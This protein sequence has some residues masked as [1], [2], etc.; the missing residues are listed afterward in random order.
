MSHGVYRLGIAVPEVEPRS[1]KVPRP[2][3]QTRASHSNVKGVNEM[4]R[5]VAGV[6]DEFA[7]CLE[8]YDQQLP[9]TRTGQY[10][11]HR[12]TID[13]RR[14]FTS[15][16]DAIEDEVF[17]RGF[18]QT[19]YAWGIGKRAS[20]L[21]SLPEFRDRL[22]DCGEEIANFEHLRLDDPELDISL[23][24]MRLWRLIERLAVVQN[25][26][27]I[28]PGTKTLHH[29]LPDLVPPMDRAW[30]GAFFQW[31]MGAPAYERST[32]IRTF[33]SFAEIAQATDPSEFVGEEWRT[34]LTKVLDNAIIGY[35]KLHD[36]APR[37]S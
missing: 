30:T 13:G 3:A 16:R 11:L 18:H 29:L 34:S 33:R 22:S 19:L 1:T 12:A 9:F 15:V 4:E 8:T 31:S 24:A 27:L 17:L 5:R 6:I 21:V 20:R 2:F 14:S 23:T 35:C 32:F 26:S 10:S 25:V 28:V 7:I 36:I 37:G